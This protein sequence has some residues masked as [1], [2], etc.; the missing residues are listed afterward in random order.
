MGGG[1]FSSEPEPAFIIMGVSAMGEK[2]FKP[3]MTER[4]FISM[5]VV[6]LRH[7]G[8]HGLR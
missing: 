5:M 7:C 3:V 4:L 2:S 6:V 8:D 1:R